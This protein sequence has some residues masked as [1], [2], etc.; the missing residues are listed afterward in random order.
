[1]QPQIDAVA[2]ITKSSPRVTART[3][4]TNP[5][6]VPQEPDALVQAFSCGR[7]V[8]PPLI[9]ETMVPFRIKEIIKEQ[10]DTIKNDLETSKVLEQ[11]A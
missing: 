6:Q 2:G 9:A 11:F 10:R 1:M 3:C 5:V 7:S 4:S 8:A